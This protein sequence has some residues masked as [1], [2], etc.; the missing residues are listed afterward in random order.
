MIHD[1]PTPG[2]LQ[3]QLR[4]K[5]VWQKRALGQHFLFDE[6][7]LARIAGAAGL[8]SGALAV[9]VGPG[10]GT[11]TAALAA[12][13]GGVLAVEFD[14][15]LRALHEDVFARGRRS[16][17]FTPTPCARTWPAWAERPP[18]GSA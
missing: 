10:A 11:L 2:F 14:E 1:L 13:A 6:A 15:R 8:D 16:S 17:S 3:L 12:R 4:L 18:R 9:E 7:L 5:G